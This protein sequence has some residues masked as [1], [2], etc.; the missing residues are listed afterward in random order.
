M[1]NL[2]VSLLVLN[3]LNQKVLAIIGSDTGGSV[4]VPAS[5]C[6]ILGFRPS[7]D[8]ISTAGVIPMAQSFDTVGHLVKH[9]V[10]GDYAKDKVPSLKPFTSNGN[11]DQ[12]Y[13][14]PSL[15][16]LSSAMRLLQRHEFKINHGEWVSTV[17]PDLGPAI[18]E[19]AR[20]ALMP[21][22][23]NMDICHSVKIE[24]RTALTAHLGLLSLSFSTFKCS[25]NLRICF[26]EIP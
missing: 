23:G 10:L 26:M 12:D 1:N 19:R 21:T 17:K 18:A 15:A 16:A 20:E 6:G 11:A 5:Y 13:N 4:R 22:D 7:H 2:Y 24:F 25:R 9:A 14:I 8:A 3:R